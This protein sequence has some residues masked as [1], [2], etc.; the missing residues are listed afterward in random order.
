MMAAERE[1]MMTKL[2]KPQLAAL[3][4]LERWGP[5]LTSQWTTGSGRWTRSRVIPPYCQKI[6]RDEAA[7]YP[8]R[9]RKTFTDSPRC[10]AVIAI[11]NMR[12][13]KKALKALAPTAGA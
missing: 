9:I 5:V 12:A 1:N 11:V 10:Q 7:K 8:A 4:I 6:Y 3:S 2:T 13:A